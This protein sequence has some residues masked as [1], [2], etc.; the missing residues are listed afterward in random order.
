MDRR[1]RAEER[2][3][4]FVIDGE[5]VVLGVD[6]VA[7][8]NAL[9]SRRHEDEVQLYAFDVLALDGDD[10]RGLPLSMR[11]TNLDR[12]LARRPDGIFVAPFEQGEIGPELFRAACR[13][14]LEG[15]VSKR[16]D[17]PY[18]AG[19]SKAWLKI[20]NRKHPATSRVMETFG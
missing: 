5:A 20:K 11:K 19:R 4:Q 2:H 3:K 16:R 14:G 7:D 8:F 18:Q 1:G 12:L 15:L 6:G 17:R 10:L 13:M 9:H